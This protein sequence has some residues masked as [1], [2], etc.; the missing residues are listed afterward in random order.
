[1]KNLKTISLIGAATMMMQVGVAHADMDADDR[2]AS[3]DK[4]AEENVE[5]GKKQESYFIL[6]C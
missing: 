2:R 4:L 1:M 3:L 5:I 6:W